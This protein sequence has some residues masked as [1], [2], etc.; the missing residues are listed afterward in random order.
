MARKRGL[1]PGA[2]SRQLTAGPGRLCQA[3][4]ITRAAHNGLDLL[5][6][7]SPLQLRDDGF[8]VSE[9]LVTTRIGIR[10]AVD[11]PLRFALPGH[12]CLSGPRSLTGSRSLLR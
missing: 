9:V 4:E 1:E 7:G 12:D 5:D 2:A 10:H 11:W 6:S 8:P 3:L